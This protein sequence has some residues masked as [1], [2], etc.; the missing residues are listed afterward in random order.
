LFIS[1]EFLHAKKLQTLQGENQN[2]SLR[3]LDNDLLER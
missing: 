2:S 1:K 3:S